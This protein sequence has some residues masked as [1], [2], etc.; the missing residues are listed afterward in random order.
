MTD[1]GDDGGVPAAEAGTSASA[2]RPGRRHCAP[3][4]AD[5]VACRG[6]L[7]GSGPAGRLRT[8]WLP[9][10]MAISTTTTAVGRTQKTK[11]T[12]ASAT[13]PIRSALRYA[14]TSGRGQKT[15]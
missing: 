14:Y 9:C 4:R 12:A 3:G 2:S 6:N 15:S 1:S 8:G 7:C 10:R 11:T 13:A 5:L